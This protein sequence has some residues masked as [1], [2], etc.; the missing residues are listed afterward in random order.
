MI[1]INLAH[2]VAE[3]S[4]F[5]AILPLQFSDHRMGQFWQ[6]DVKIF[7]FTSSAQIGTNLVTEFWQLSA[8]SAMYRLG[9][10]WQQSAENFLLYQLCIDWYQ[11]GNRVPEFFCNLGLYRFG[12]FHKSDK[13]HATK[14]TKLIISSRSQLRRLRD[15][16]NSISRGALAG[17]PLVISQE[18]W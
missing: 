3:C 5:F 4:E 9:P 8:I 6:Q 16:G 1:F 7:C 2:S 18:G 15:S 14:W 12:P 10:I 11:F 13:I 17:P